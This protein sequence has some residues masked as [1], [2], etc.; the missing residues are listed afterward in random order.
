MS[1][2]PTPGRERPVGREPRAPSIDRPALLAL[3]D[4]PPVRGGRRRILVVDD[5]AGMRYTA[6]RILERRFDVSEA[7]SGEDALRMLETESFHIAIVDVR[8]PGLSGLDLLSALKAVSPATDVIVMTGSVADVDETLEAAIRRKAFFFLR[9]PFPMTVLETLA[10][11]V[12]ETQELE[13]R[14][15]EYA[16]ALE[17]SLESARIFQRGLL[18]PLSFTTKF[19]RIA[20]IYHASE[21][22]SGDFFDYWDLPDGGTAIFVADVMGHG[23]PAAMITG[24]VKSQVRSLSAEI[25][26]PG[27]ILRALEEELRRVALKGFLTAF[28]IVDRPKDG[29]LSFAGAGH[30][31]VLYL[32]PTSDGSASD[33]RPLHSLGIPINTGLA[34]SD[35]ET[36]R[37]VREPGARLLLYTDGYPEGVS[38]HGHVFGEPDSERGENP[39]LKAAGRALEAGSPEAGIAL[40]ESKWQE[41]VAGQVPEDDRAGVMVWVT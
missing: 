21:R 31:P 40:L 41:F 17:R 11:R 30:P 7:A 25:R 29:S 22:L 3:N 27:A 32:R 38:P 9:K 5:E 28:L 24:I 16:R 33:I 6:R 26:D 14:L 39:F 8:L 15:V 10:E 23:P 12:V 2:D 13:E 35:R 1:P 36:T 4:L 20:S 19:L 18:P 34:I 37:L